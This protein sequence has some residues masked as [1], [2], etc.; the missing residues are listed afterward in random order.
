MQNV[1][2]YNEADGYFTQ[3]MMMPHSDLHP[4]QQGVDGCSGLTCL[5]VY[6]PEVD[7][8]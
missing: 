8:T 4:L 1:L 3:S 7:G 5:I 6:R 2:A